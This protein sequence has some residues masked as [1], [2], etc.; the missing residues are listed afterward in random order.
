MNV[1]DPTS[2]SLPVKVNWLD[3]VQIVAILQD[4]A[5]IQCYDHETTEELRAVLI[6][7]IEDGDIPEH[8]IDQQWG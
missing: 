8:V 6:E 4:V 1:N 2:L 3:R 5:C 7:C